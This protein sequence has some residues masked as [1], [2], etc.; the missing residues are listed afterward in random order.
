[1]TIAID[2]LGPAVRRYAIGMQCQLEA[3]PRDPARPST[4]DASSDYLSCATCGAIV[5]I[6]DITQLEPGRCPGSESAV[7]AER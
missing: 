3:L 7:A 1:M 6:G 5:P 4:G 2:D